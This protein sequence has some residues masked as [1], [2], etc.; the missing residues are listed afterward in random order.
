[1]CMLYLDVTQRFSNNTDTGLHGRSSGMTREGRG[2]LEMEEMVQMALTDGRGLIKD[3]EFILSAL[4]NQ[5]RALSNVYFD[6]ISVVTTWI[7]GFL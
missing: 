4:G 5:Q 6:S 3:L 1:M 7:K 2:R